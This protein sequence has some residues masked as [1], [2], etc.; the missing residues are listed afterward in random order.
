VP[1]GVVIST[2]LASIAVTPAMTDDQAYRAMVS[3]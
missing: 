1:F 3:H 2:V